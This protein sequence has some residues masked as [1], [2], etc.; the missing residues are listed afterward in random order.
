MG[1]QMSRAMENQR[2]STLLR[3]FAEGDETDE[4]WTFLGNSGDGRVK[5]NHCDFP[6]HFFSQNLSLYSILKQH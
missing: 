4:K 5:Q 3:T 6:S 1:R 2:L